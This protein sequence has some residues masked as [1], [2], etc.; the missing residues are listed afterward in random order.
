M[1]QVATGTINRD[2]LRS[3]DGKILRMRHFW[4]VNIQFK[5]NKV[6]MQ[7]LDVQHRYFADLGSL[8]PI[9]NCPPLLTLNGAR[10]VSAS[11][12]RLISTQV[13]FPQDGNRQESFLCLVSSWSKLMALTQR[14]LSCPFL[15]WGKFCLIVEQ[16]L[17]TLEFP[18]HNFG[19]HNWWRLVKFCNK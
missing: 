17:T 13:N 6:K 19:F 12:L 16:D 2:D 7:F 5:V 4:S 8:V 1:T 3:E 15:S 9:E 10:Q 11:L 14:K 18:T